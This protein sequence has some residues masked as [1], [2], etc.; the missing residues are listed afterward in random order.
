MI[1]GVK[2]GLKGTRIIPSLLDLAQ[3]VR[4]LS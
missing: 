4:I 2:T 1:V 3:Y